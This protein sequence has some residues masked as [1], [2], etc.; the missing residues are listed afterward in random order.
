MDE[1]II[2]RE[3]D[4]LRIELLPSI[5]F[6]GVVESYREVGRLDR[7]EKLPRLWLLPDDFPEELLSELDFEHLKALVPEGVSQEVGGRAALVSSSDVMYGKA[8]QLIAM[9]PDQPERFA[10]FRTEAE[11]LAWLGV[12]E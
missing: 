11:A 12:G 8:R 1:F 10:V 5:T 3:A 6:Q 9:R 2:T 4:H 7:I